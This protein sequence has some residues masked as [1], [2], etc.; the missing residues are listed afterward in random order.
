MSNNEP[1]TLGWEFSVIHRFKSNDNDGV[2]PSGHLIMGPHS[3]IFGVAKSSGNSSGDGHGV[4]YALNP[5]G[6][7][8]KIK[9]NY[10]VIHRFGE[11]GHDGAHPVGGL[12]LG[13]DGTLYGTTAAGG[14]GS[15]VVFRIKPEDLNTVNSPYKVIYNF[16]N[17]DGAAPRASLIIDSSGRLFGTTCSGGQ[18]GGGT[19]FMLEKNA[20]DHYNFTKLHDFE[21]PQ[22]DQY[23]VS[24]LTFDSKGNLYGTTAT[25]GANNAGEIF[26]LLVDGNGTYRYKRLWSF[27]PTPIGNNAVLPLGDL[28][29]DGDQKLYGILSQGGEVE[30]GAVF[31]INVKDPSQPTYK[32]IYDFSQNISL[33][34]MSGVIL[35]EKGNLYGTTQD[36]SIPDVNG[37]I[38]KLRNDGENIFSYEELFRF[39]QDEDGQYPD[40]SLLRLPSG[41]LFGTT[42]EGGGN[43]TFGIVFCCF[44]PVVIPPR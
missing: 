39:K 29:F 8:P 19:V 4:V 24:G 6:K 1:S 22:A 17:A 3:I 2:M 37:T 21:A 41:N 34:P 16:S 36:S 12:V 28:C 14:K 7:S 43:E 38:Y 20:D 35:D 33:A 30:A 15:G 32:E 31:F 11:T 18:Y 27:D 26:G 44:F 13:H 9:Y 10:H 42:S 23:S 25:G 40:S 5:D